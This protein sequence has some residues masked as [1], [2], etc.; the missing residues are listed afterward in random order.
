MRSKE[1]VINIIR[2]YC[3]ANDG[4]E[5]TTDLLLA[6]GAEIRQGGYGEFG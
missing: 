2:S 3:L 5:A 1:D 4:D 6:I